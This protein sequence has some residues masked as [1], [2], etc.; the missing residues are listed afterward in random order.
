MDRQSI[1]SEIEH[2]RGEIRR[3]NDLYYK[4][5]SP[6]IS[7]QEYD[8]LERKL[9]D[10]EA[11][12]PELAGAGSPTLQVGSDQ[13]ARFPSLPHSRPMLSLANS[14]DPQDVEDFVQ[15]TRRDLGVE[16]VEFTVEPK[17]DGVALALRY[18]GGRL[19]TALT[20]GDGRKGDVI[21]ANIRTMAGLPFELEA[22]WAQV[23]PA[24]PPQAF[25]V[26]GEAYLSLSRFRQLNRMRAAEGLE[27]LANPRNATAGTLKTL[28]ARAV[29]RRGLSAFF[30]QLFPLP[31]EG[32]QARDHDTHEQELQAIADL[33]LPCNP[34]LR[35]AGSVAG[36]MTHLET[37]QEMRDGLDYQIDGAVIKVN[38]RDLQEKLGTT[39]KSPRWALA[40]KYPA[41]EAVT[42]LRDIT[43]Q[44]GRTGVITPVAELEPVALAGSI[45]SRATLHNWDE[46]TRK[47]IR[48]GDMVVVVKGGDIIPKVLRVLV[49]KRQGT[50]RPLPPPSHCPVCGAPVAAGSDQVAL[51]C[52]N[53]LC[54]AVLAGRLR[55]FAGRDAA[56]ID[57]LGGKWVETFLEMGLVQTPADL[58]ELDKQQLA[59]LPG[60]GEKSAERLLA[61][62]DKARERPWSARIFSLG[63]PQV[64][65]TTARTLASRF[66]SID[67]L[68]NAGTEDLAALPDIGPVVAE[69]IVGYWQDPEAA[70]L[71][72]RLKEHGYFHASEEL[73][74]AG[75]GPSA[76]PLAGKTVVL[77]GTLETMTRSRA[78]ELV[79][80]A[81]GKLT[82]SVSRKTDFVV[83]GGKPGSKLARA[84][85]L[86]VEVLDEEAF[87]AL[88]K[89]GAGA[90]HEAG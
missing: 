62:L 22:D 76:G 88:V 47:D 5:A 77:T 74:D 73:E 19:D 24:P 31:A 30:Y 55:H 40:F 2:L 87:L 3:H 69:A 11:R 63:I 45:V 81:G 17:I 21:T 23:F 33:G 43:M 44:V 29:A 79:A 37:L 38:R 56:D 6:V 7:D 36:I 20:R 71:I 41:A 25:E 14:Y 32:D 48:I 52:T 4:H 53:S 72:Q 80:A 75:A 61:G 90:G 42:R 16:E 8:A 57:G 28:D 64:G 59:V 86:G 12:Y 39:A 66:G 10:L 85:Q 9:R 67:D 15:R 49:D 26:R 84:R 70:R 13:D 46:M 82:S 35:K 54:P 83:A 58:F 78:G 18:R 50:E 68:M 51:R 1:L 65:I 60:W 89:G 34:F 27:P